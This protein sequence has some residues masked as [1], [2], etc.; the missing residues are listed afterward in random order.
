MLIVKMSEMN[1]YTTSSVSTGVSSP[2]LALNGKS[3]MNIALITEDELL[4]QLSNVCVC[5]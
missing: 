3:V 2:D 5:V 4:W 1:Q